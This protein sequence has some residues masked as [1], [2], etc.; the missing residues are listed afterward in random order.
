[1]KFLKKLFINDKAFYRKVLILALP[2]ALQSLITT[3]VNLLD[4]MMLGR[5]GADLV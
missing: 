1:M 2:I 3:G 4:N 5:V